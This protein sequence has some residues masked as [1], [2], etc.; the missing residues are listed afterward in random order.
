MKK[1]IF[2]WTLSALGLLSVCTYVCI[3]LKK[4]QPADDKIGVIGG[5]DAPTFML[6]MKDT[7]ALPLIVGLLLLAFGIFLLI[8]RNKP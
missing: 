6:L 8:K 2:G 3:I 7:S 4:M 1:R 5:A